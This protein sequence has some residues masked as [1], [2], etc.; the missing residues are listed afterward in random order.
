MTSTATVLP[1][2]LRPDVLGLSAA[3]TAAADAVMLSIS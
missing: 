2:L 1:S 3:A